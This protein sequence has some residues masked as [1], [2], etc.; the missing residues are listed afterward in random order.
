MHLDRFRGRIMFPIHNHLGKVVGFTGR[1]LPQFETGEA[2][3]YMNSPETP[4]FGKSKLLYGF[5]KSK[6]PIREAGNAFLVEGQMDF[7]MSWQAGVRNTVASSGTALT[8]DHLR[9]LRRVTQELVVSFDS[10]DAGR[11]AGERAIDLAEANDFTV[12]VVTFADYKDPAEAAVADPARLSAMV[13]DARPAME[14]YFEKY[15]PAGSVAW[16]NRDGLRRLRAVLAKIT[17]MASPVVRGFWVREL[18]RRTGI[19]ERLLIEETERVET[20]RSVSPSRAP[21]QEERERAAPPSR[22]ELLSQ[23]LLGVALARE[24]FGIVGEHA[25][26]LMPRYR[27]VMELLERG[28]RASD[29]PDL[30]ARIHLTVLS[31]DE[32]THEEIEDL[33]IHLAREYFRERRRELTERVK[34]AE[35]S[36]DEAALHAALGEFNELPTP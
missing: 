13:R 29:D 14:F 1:V 19:E 7:L 32:G 22:W 18:S 8:P 5:W 2:G 31:G 20:K 28:V 33:K 16:Q 21:D 27:S 36:G 3:K 34:H 11:E 23:R 15:L 4:I 6:N 35:A 12:R 25:A 17:N 10:D 9:A 30:D 26:Y 24:D